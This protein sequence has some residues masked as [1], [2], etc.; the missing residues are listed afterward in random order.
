M[1]SSGIA[2]WDTD[3]RIAPATSLTTELDAASINRVDIVHARNE[4]F[5]VAKIEYGRVST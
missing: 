5:A 1:L 4:E 3:T 2:S